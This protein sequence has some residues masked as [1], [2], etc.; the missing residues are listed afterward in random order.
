MILPTYNDELMFW[1][2]DD[3]ARIAS[4]LDEVLQNLH[5]QRQQKSAVRDLFDLPFVDDQIA[6]STQMAD[7]VRKKFTDLVVIGIGGSDLGTRAVYHAL[8]ASASRGMRPHFIGANTDPDEM[9]ALLSKIDFTKTAFNVISKSGDTVEPWVAFLILREQ[10]IKVVG[11]KAHREHVIVTTSASHG[12]LRQFAD[13]QGYRVLVVP[14]TIGGRFS[15]FTN[16][17]F[18][19]LACAGISIEEF[20]KGARTMHEDFFASGITSAPVKF[21]RAQYI[22]YLEGKTVSVLMPYRA[23]LRDIG[24]WWRQL[25]AESLGKK[26]DRSRSEVFHGLTPVVAMGATDQHSQLQLYNEGPLDKIVTFLS[27]GQFAQ[28]FV[29]PFSKSA[30]KTVSLLAG[31]RMGNILEMERMATAKSL[32]SHGRPNGSLF[33]NAINESSLGALMYF[34]MLATLMMAE[35]LAID[36]FDQPG[37]DEGKK[38]LHENLSQWQIDHPRSDKK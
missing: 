37:V 6:E 14:E 33:I 27:V 17:S 9:T 32:A 35:L 30:A 15:V 12:D 23:S 2:S 34:F 24:E 26:F 18:F 19:P 1:G 29:V 21:A 20:Q 22:G 28:D 13:E 31:Q 36:A 5:D 3:N 11:E 4:W 38:I 8:D 16:V 25:W 7:E 10:L